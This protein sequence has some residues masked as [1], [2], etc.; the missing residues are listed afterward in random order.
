M[1][2]S[3]TRVRGHE[4]RVERSSVLPNVHRLSPPT[5]GTRSSSCRAGLEFRG[6]PWR[7]ILHS[8]TRVQVL[9]YG[10]LSRR[11]FPPPSVV[12]GMF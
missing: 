3:P 2:S 10:R 7:T 9:D 6:D 1:I 8:C 12:K 4:T 11:P 5:H